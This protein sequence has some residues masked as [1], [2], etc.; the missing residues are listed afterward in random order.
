MGAVLDLV[1]VLYEPT[2][3]FERI[4]ERPRFVAPVTAIM[5]LS[6]V[7]GLLMRPFVEAA[8]GPMLAQAAAARGGAAPDAGKAALLQ[9]VG[10]TVFTPV[11]IA[12]IGGLLWVAVSLFGVE[13]RY[14]VLVSVAAYT[15][16]LYILQL[17]AA[18]AVLAL[19]G[20][21]S[22]SSP[23]DLQPAFG[24]DLLAPDATGFVGGLLRGVNV[25][26]VWGGVLNGI[27]ITVTHRT[28]KQTGYGAAVIA[29]VATVLLAS[30]LGL[31]Q[32][33]PPR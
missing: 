27:G 31:L 25:F 3:V 32:P 7:I 9:L 12:L 15:S 19:R 10:A 2:A 4:R 23:L 29:V 24:L 21:A 14:R 18:L 6:L 30:L 17:L 11:F 8:L 26:S 20:V 1:R 22:V 33:Q 16:I 13:A 28:S 5:A